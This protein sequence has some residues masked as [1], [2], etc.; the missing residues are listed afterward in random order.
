MGKNSGKHFKHKCFIDLKYDILYYGDEKADQKNSKKGK[1]ILS[2]EGE[3]L[4]I[5]FKKGELLNID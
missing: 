3:Q 2:K 1:I 5:D 4:K